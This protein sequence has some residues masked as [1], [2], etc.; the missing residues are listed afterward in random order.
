MA[1]DFKE[2]RHMPLVRPAEQEPDMVFDQEPA[3]GAIL[4]IG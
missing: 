1:G 4:A 2:Q 3:A